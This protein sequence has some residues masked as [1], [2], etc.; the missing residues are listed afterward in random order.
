MGFDGRNCEINIDEC[1]SKPCKNNG[2]CSDLVNGFHCDCRNTG[3]FGLTC[4]NNVSLTVK[5]RT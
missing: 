5:S 4:E 1:Q 3:F 2:T